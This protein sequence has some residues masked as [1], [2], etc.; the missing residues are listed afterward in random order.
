MQGLATIGTV[1]L[2]VQPEV[3]L[4]HADARPQVPQLPDLLHVVEHVL[5]GRVVVEGFDF[6]LRVFIL[7][8]Q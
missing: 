3:E 2:S 1:P 7:V 6:L 5:K 8:A 4:P